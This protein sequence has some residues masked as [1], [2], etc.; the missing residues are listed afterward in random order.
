LKK[1]ANTIAAKLAP[2]AIKTDSTAVVI[3]DAAV[4]ML[5]KVSVLGGTG[6]ICTKRIVSS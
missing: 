6:S 2:T 3:Q 5:R 4:K 1:K